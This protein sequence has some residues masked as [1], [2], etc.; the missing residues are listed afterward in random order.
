MAQK[1]LSDKTPAEKAAIA[2][3]LRRKKITTVTVTPLTQTVII[4][5]AKETR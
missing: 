3:I 2:R 5:Q 1:N 4:K